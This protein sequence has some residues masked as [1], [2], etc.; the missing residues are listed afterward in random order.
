MSSIAYQA[1][2]RTCRFCGESGT[3]LTHYSVRSY[4]HAAC[5]FETK[6]E[7][8]LRALSLHA[9]ET[10]PVLPLRR[11]GLSFD[12]LCELLDERKARQR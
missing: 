4:A 5:L 12:R 10:L 9:L 2:V 6:G 11:A 8:G 1:P 7:D 3:G